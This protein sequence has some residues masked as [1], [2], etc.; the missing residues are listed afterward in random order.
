MAGL[1]LSITPF[2]LELYL[3]QNL[4]LYHTKFGSQHDSITW[5]YSKLKFM[6][7]Q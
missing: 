2:A 1:F 7:P 5:C 6:K 4:F 3:G